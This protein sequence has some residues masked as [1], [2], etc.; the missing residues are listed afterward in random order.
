M[1]ASPVS[2][3]ITPGLNT[4][5]PAG[6]SGLAGRARGRFADLWVNERWFLLFLMA[7]FVAAGFVYDTPQVAMWFGFAMAAYSTVANDSLQTIGTF[8]SSNQQRPWWVLWLFIG[9]IF[10]LTVGWSWWAYD[11]DVTYQRLASKGFEVAPTSF[12]YLQ[13]AAP[14]FLV[15]LTRLRMP[16]S[17]TFLIL[18][19]FA[20][21]SAGIG[22]MVG[23]SLLGYG[24]AFAGALVVW[25]AGYT[26]MKRRF[27]GPA[28]PAWMVGQ[29][30]TSG[31]L[32]SVW[33]MQDASNIA[34]YLPRQLG[35]WE[36]VAFASVMFFGLGVIFWQRGD[37]IQ[38]VITEKSDTL[39]VRPATVIDLVYTV[40]LFLF[41]EVSHIPM[42]TTWVFV[43][44]LA[45]RELAMAWRSRGLTRSPREALKLMGRDLLYA[46]IGLL[47]SLGIA[48]AVNDGIAA[49]LRAL[50]GP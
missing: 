45:G 2:R 17:T 10:L 26:W 50:L 32:W 13:V 12:S 43:G 20:A 46:A 39:D 7:A 37:R 5:P 6:P 19:S 16:V 44:L 40:I 24:V 36:F 35:V 28:H 30:L 18:S 21:G 34:V 49:E 9:G 47:V 4:A 11:G 27:Q 33:L 14:I 3:P 29:W 1:S 23:K 48:A 22:G 42:S 41:K 8:L 15:I 31:A 25:S 38:E